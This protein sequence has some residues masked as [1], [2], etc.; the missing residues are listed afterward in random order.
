MLSFRNCRLVSLKPNVTPNLLE[1]S[2]RTERLIYSLGG[3]IITE[4][5]VMT[6]KQASLAVSAS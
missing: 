4:D 5:L 3:R 1:T 2:D 6:Y